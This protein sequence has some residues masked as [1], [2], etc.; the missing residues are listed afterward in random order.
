MRLFPDWRQVPILLSLREPLRYRL[1]LLSPAAARKSACRIVP[2]GSAH[3]LIYRRDSSRQSRLPGRLYRSRPS[4]PESHLGFVRV[5]HVR[6]RQS[7]HRV[8]VRLRQ[9][10]QGK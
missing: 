2:A 4:R 6:R 5:R 10:R 8:F 9:L 3:G 1:G 7:R